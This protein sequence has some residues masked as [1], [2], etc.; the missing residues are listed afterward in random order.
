MIVLDVRDLSR[1]SSSSKA[2]LTMCSECASVMLWKFHT[3]PRSQGSWE[4]IVP[5]SLADDP[6]EITLLWDEPARETLESHC[7]END[8]LEYAAYAVAIA[9]ADHLGFK[10]LARVHQGSGADWLMVPRGEPRNDY[11]KLEVSGI[12]R[13]NAEKPESRLQTKVAQGSGG[14]LVRP[15]VAVV[16]RFEDIRV[17]SE[18]WI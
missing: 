15:G 13:I 12:A 1:F 6:V 7:N 17:L 8:A 10:V 9:L 16:T 14:D 4:S 11:Y 2:L 18:A 3:A 5:F